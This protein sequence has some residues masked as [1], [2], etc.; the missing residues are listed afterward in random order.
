M[1]KQ[2]LERWA[3]GVSV[4]GRLLSAAEL[5]PILMQAGMRLLREAVYEPV[6]DSGSVFRRRA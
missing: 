4:E 6:G 5:K 3:T 2:K 1:Q